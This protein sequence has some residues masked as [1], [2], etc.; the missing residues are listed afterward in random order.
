MFAIPL[1]VIAQ[2]NTAPLFENTAYFTSIETIST[3]GLGTTEQLVLGTNTGL[4]RSSRVGGVQAATSQSDA[5]WVQ[6]DPA[7]YSDITGMD[8]AWHVVYPGPTDVTSRAT[9]WPISLQ[10]QNNLKT[11]DR[12]SIHQLNGT[13]DA[14]PFN[15]VPDDFN[16]SQS[17]NLQFTTLPKIYRFWSDGARRFF[18]ITMPQD[19]SGK[20]QI[21]VL[22]YDTFI[23]QVATP[24]NQ[25]LLTGVL[26]ISNTFHWVQAIGMSGIVLAGT[27]SGVI[28]LE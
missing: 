24:N 1:T 3:N 10:D 12:S 18:I 22:P 11:F 27:N 16:S 6:I 17:N 7:F 26:P 23:T 5:A 13:T 20:N 4:Y 21:I 9:V 2:S 28:A 15:F 8:N 25:L 14:G 19:S